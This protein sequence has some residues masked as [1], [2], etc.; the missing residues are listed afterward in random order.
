MLAGNGDG[1]AHIRNRLR[2][3]KGIYYAY[4]LR[5]IPESARVWRRKR[6]NQKETFIDET[7]LR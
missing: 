1:N 3:F 2:I 4:R 6:L 5:R 7:L